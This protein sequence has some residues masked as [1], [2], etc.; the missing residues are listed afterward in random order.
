MLQIEI[1]D[2]DGQWTPNSRKPKN[3]KSNNQTFVE[4]NKAPQPDGAPKLISRSHLARGAI[5][6]YTYYGSKG[7]ATMPL[8]VW[9]ALR[10][11]PIASQSFA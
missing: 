3:S 5:Y 7:L 11:I 9:R 1:E 8:K 10:L 4:S 6:V 2:V